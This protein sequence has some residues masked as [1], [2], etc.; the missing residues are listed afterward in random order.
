MNKKKVI[1]YLSVIVL[2]L[3]IFLVIKTYKSLNLSPEDPTACDNSAHNDCYKG[4][5][6][7]ECVWLKGT[8]QGQICNI[9]ANCK[10]YPTGTKYW[11]QGEVSIGAV[12]LKALKSLIPGL[13]IFTAS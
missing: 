7:Y 13:D 1:F 12:I 9:D 4:C 11:S 3:F 8:S 6:N 2:A 5:V 10:F